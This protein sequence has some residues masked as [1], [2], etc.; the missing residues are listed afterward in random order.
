MKNTG[1]FADTFETL[2]G[3]LATALIVVGVL[4]YAWQEP[5]RIVMAQEDQLASDLDEAM[6]LYAENCSVC[7]GIA[8]EGIGSTPALDSLAMQDSDYASLDKII[9]RGLF[10]TAMP[11]WSVED[12][13]PLIT[14]SVN[15]YR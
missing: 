6:T 5:D 9:S 7:H 15:W 1:R 13:G 10:N 4:L 14:K 8:G 11:A 12:G 2:I 3:I